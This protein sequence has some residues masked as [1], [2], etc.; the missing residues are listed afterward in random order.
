LG[1]RLS[2]YMAN[3]GRLI[4]TIPTIV[5]ETLHRFLSDSI[6]LIT[7]A[8][9]VPRRELLSIGAA[10]FSNVDDAGHRRSQGEGC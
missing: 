9:G 1:F 3:P 2:L 4:V 7:A 5:H 6:R 10:T 8:M